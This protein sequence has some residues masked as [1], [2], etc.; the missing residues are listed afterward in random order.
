M[1]IFKFWRYV[2]YKLY[3]WMYNPKSGT[4]VSEYKAGSTF[5][6]MHMLLLIS[7]PIIID[8]VFKTQFNKYF[9]VKNHPWYPYIFV[10]LWIGS[11][12]IFFVYKRRYKKIIS[13]FKHESD[14]KYTIGNLLVA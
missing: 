7:I 8:L 13:E 6:L 10:P 5:A 11:I 3:S 2:Y 14:N 12:M 4:D 9:L 1:K